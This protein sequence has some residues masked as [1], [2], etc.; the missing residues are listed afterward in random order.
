MKHGDVDDVHGNEHEMVFWCHVCQT[1][2]TAH[3]NKVDDP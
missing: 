3:E 1:T 2:R